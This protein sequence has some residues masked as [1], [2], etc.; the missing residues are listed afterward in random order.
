MVRESFQIP[1]WTA[2]SGRVSSAEGTWLPLI[3]LDGGHS[4][5]S[6]SPVT[7]ASGEQNFAG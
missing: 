7:A 3:P 4:A 2:A 1:K 5:I 6:I